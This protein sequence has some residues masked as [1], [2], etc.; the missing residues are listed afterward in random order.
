[1]EYGALPAPIVEL[2]ADSAER[3]NLQEMAGY[4]ANIAVLQE[5]A[6]GAGIMNQLPDVD[7]IIRRVPLVVRY[8][9]QL[10]P[11]LALEMARLY[12][13]E[14][15]FE[16]ITYPLGDTYQVEGIRIGRSAG[17]YELATD[18]RAQVLVP[19]VGPSVLNG[20]GQ[21]V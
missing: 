12:Y 14:Q 7:G 17:Q 3:V 6:A 13:F 9:D 4:T 15:D 21:Y 5:A 10:Y 19:Y 20:N 8:R 16:L 1:M 11:T 18:A 2:D